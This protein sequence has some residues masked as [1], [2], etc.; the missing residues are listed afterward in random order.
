MSIDN[1]KLLDCPYCGR[2]AELY[3]GREMS[4]TS[5]V[6]KIRCS[7]LN[8]LVIEKALSLASPDYDNKVKSMFEDWNSAV[9]IINQ[10]NT[11]NS[12]CKEDIL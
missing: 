1:V 4:D 6:H 9:A 11:K 2:A 3:T 10:N 8:C 7:Y 12:I 5:R